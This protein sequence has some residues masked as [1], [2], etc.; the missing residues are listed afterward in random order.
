MLGY[1]L[2]VAKYFGA[3][4]HVLYVCELKVDT[5]APSIVRYQLLQEE[6]HRAQQEL[7]DFIQ[8]FAVHQIKVI[9]EVEIG[10]AKENIPDYIRRNKEIDLLVL[11]LNDTTPRIQ[12][13]IWGTTILSVLENSPIPVLIIPKGILFQDIK[14]LA[15]LSPII[16]NWED[17]YQSL[18][19]LAIYFSA[20][21][22]VAHPRESRHIPS[23]I[24][25]QHHVLDNYENDLQSFIHNENLQLLVTVASARNTLQRL[26]KYSAAQKMALRATIPLLVWKK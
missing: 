13:A 22:L 1:T 17:N 11:G 10:F 12:K 24:P 19:D 7:G 16:D 18:K 3:E 14:N 26:L 9:Q 20:N 15:Y 4:V 23:P 8:Q 2:A 21:L 6:K 25:D 5:M